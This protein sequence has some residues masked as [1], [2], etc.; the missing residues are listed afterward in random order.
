MPKRS[1][2]SDESDPKR[3]ANAYVLASTKPIGFDAFERHPIV[4][5]LTDGIPLH[6]A[7]GATLAALIGKQHSFGFDNRLKQLPVD[8]HG[9]VA[10]YVFGPPPY[11]RK[12]AECLP[13]DRKCF[14][15]YHSLGD[16]LNNVTR[17]VCAVCGEWDQS[18]VNAFTCEVCAVWSTLCSEC[19]AS[20]IADG[21]S[22]YLYYCM[23]HY[24]DIKMRGTRYH[25]PARN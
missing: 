11:T 6:H 13:G 1:H 14:W 9:L 7:H 4:D 22:D 8:V 3:Q 12:G 25:R 21:R 24:R 19:R 17:C 15:Y 10:R 23:W 18:A 20:R 16:Y 2:D 5:W